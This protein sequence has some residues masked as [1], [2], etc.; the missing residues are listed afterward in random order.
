MLESTPRQDSLVVYKGRPARVRRAAKTLE[1]EL[2]DGESLTV[3][4][5]DVLLLHPGPLDSLPAHLPRG[6]VAIAWELLAGST[7]DLPEL[8][9]LAFG[10]YSP[11]TAWA[12][13]QWVTDGL[14]FRGTPQELVVRSEE[15]VAREQAAR[16]ARAEEEQAWT[17]FLSRL[18]SNRV[19]SEDSRYLREVEDLALGRRDRSR[20]LRE[21]GQAETPE[22]AHGLLLRLGW[23]DQAVDPYP[24]RL[25]LA[26]MPV[27]IEMPELLPEERLDLTHLPAFAIDDEGNQEPDDALSLDGPLRFPLRCAPG[28]RAPGFHGRLWVHVADVA[29]V[30][31]PDS[32]VDVEARARG[33]TLYLPEGPVRMLPESAVRSLGLG[34]V[35]R[36]PALSFGLDVGSDGHILGVEIVP[37]WVRVTR[38]SYEEAETQ[39][40]EEPFR[41]L[42]A[43]A[44]LHQARRREQGA[45]AIELPEVK[46]QV[47]DGTVSIRPLPPLR[48]RDLVTEGMVMA[49]AAL[50]QFGR[51]HDIPLPYTTQEAPTTDTRPSSN[52]L[53][54]DLAGMF[55]LRRHFRPSQYSSN[56]GPHAGLGLEAYVQAT[57][58]LRRY[59]DLVV[60]QQLRAHLRGAGMLGT[61]ELLE[62]VGAT[63]AVAGTVRHAER[64]A[65]R[66]WTLVYLMQHPG[67]EGEG[68][69]V[70]ERARRVTVLIPELDLDAQVALRKDIPLN[71]RVLLGWTEVNL[72]EL[73]V[74]L[75]VVTS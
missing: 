53:G 1:I 51:E 20:V 10:S 62:R 21:V 30:V 15:E 4:P 29:A 18:R 50:A 23:W 28:P 68:V 25:G 57:S 47:I 22:K 35:E 60:H 75:R 38:L 2:Q 13:W 40:G 39:L 56:P 11:A 31:W 36:S 46:I 45:V 70:E 61:A 12:A 16:L 52:V 48:S 71:D 43:L 65:R 74:H 19:V 5:K 59:L 64:L 42:W 24:Q 7:T 32:A 41:S 34:L 44:Q 55:G 33:A 26:T 37:S 73:D 54:Q 8:A 58:P 27:A 9:E 3:R 14:Y 6:E 69:V 72:P 17:A 49:G 67:W 66:H 63:M